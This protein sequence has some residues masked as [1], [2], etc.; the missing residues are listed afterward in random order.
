MNQI[1]YKGEI[2]GGV[3]EDVTSKSYGNI[4]ITNPFT[5]QEQVFNNV[6]GGEN[7]EIFNNYSGNNKNVAMG[8]NST[9]IGTSNKELK[10]NDSQ[11]TES[12]TGFNLISGAGNTLINGTYNFITG[13][14][15]WI[16][17]TNMSLI[18][19]AHNYIKQIERSLIAGIYNTVQNSSICILGCNNEAINSTVDNGTATV[20][21]NYNFITGTS[22]IIGNNCKNTES[23]SQGNFLLKNYT[24]GESLINKTEG[25]LVVG[26]YNIEKNENDQIAFLIGNGYKDTTTTYRSDCLQINKDGTQIITLKD[27]TLSNTL[28]IG[29]I[30]ITQEKIIFESLKENSSQEIETVEFTF[31]DLKQIKQNSQLPNLDNNSY[32]TT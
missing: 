17:N 1:L 15:N 14:S 11:Y 25:T 13:P 28:G 27:K 7:S 5:S 9:I 20:I 29:K 32:P 19:G 16:N 18:L 12:F 24:I 2:F 10:I 31:E 30:E 22:F 23:N 4:T 8:I 6:T 21:G 26:E 3:G